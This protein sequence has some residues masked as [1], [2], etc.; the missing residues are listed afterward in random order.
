LTA[1]IS[2]TETIEGL[3]ETV[4]FLEFAESRTRNFLTVSR[5]ILKVAPIESIPCLVDFMGQKKKTDFT[6]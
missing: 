1:Q 2:I 6:G 3:F 5:I 4:F